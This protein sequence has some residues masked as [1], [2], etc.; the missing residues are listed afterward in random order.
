MYIKIYFDDKPLFLCNDID[1][2]IQPL[3]HHDDSIFIDELNAHTV[4]AMI[5]E[6]QQTQVHAGIFFHNDLE[7]LIKAFRKKFSIVK[8]GGGVVFNENKEILLIFRKG[9]WDLPKGKLDKGET[10]ESCAIRETEEETGL[11]NVEPGKILTTTY[12]TYHEGARYRLK[13]TDWFEM[14]VSG[15]QE[16]SPQIKE[17]I[18]EAKWVKPT[19][20]GTYMNNSYASVQDVL[21]LA[22]N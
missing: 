18:T 8:A 9:K 4:K 7:E 12:H 20:I 6:M 1:A 19:D 11:K 3:I 22:L 15:K 21:Q 17:D 5:H 16:L 14:H 2:T 10:L 13:V